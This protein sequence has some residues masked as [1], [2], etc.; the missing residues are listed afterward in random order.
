M[1]KEIV[2]VKSVQEIESILFNQADDLY[3]IENEI[4]STENKN[5]IKSLGA[6]YLIKKCLIDFL[7]L[8]DGY[9]AI[10]IQEERSG[11]PVVTVN[12]FVQEAIADRRIQN[13]HVSISHSR[14]FVSVLVVLEK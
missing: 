1:Y 2:S 13:I 11:K 5:V 4:K 10:E 7:D 9:Q 8:R 12:G 14:N 6:R 3:F